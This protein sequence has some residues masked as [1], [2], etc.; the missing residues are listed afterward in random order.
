MS[1]RREK[2][3]VQLKVTQS[4]EA[5]NNGALHTYTCVHSSELLT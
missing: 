2:V 1:Q 4:D 3:R 5:G